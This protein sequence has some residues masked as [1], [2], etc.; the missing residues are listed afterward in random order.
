MQRIYY[1]LF[2]LVLITCAPKKKSVADTSPGDSANGGAAM[3]TQITKSNPKAS[4]DCALRSDVVLPE[5]I[6]KYLSYL[7]LDGRLARIRDFAPGWCHFYEDKHVPYYVEG[8]FDDDAFIEKAMIMTTDDGPKV[9]ITIIDQ[10]SD[11]Q[12]TTIVL[13]SWGETRSLNEAP[14]APQF[15]FGLYTKG[16]GELYNAETDSS[17]N[18][19]RPYLALTYFEGTTVV[20]YWTA[21]GYKKVNASAD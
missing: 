4:K 1:V 18:I 5:D 10:L 16:P 3:S 7:A 21:D 15:V 11:L 13:D 6:S 19:P 12:Y 20:Y 9:N 17:F 14:K 8:N 2:V